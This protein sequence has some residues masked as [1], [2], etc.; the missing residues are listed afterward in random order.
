MIDA[1]VRLFAARLAQHQ[2]VQELR[3]AHEHTLLA[4]GLALEQRDFETQGHTLR[5]AEL[6]VSLARA[7][8]LGEEAQE[9]L[10]RGAY[11]HDVG[12]LGIP[13]TVL[14]K[15]GRLTPRNVP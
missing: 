11:L 8:G 15:P 10:R 12:K 14:L 3:A 4:L 7:L 6:S 5:V 1:V 2:A 9:L 13:D